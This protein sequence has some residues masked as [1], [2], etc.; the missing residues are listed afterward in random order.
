MF[1]M[2]E[3]K[4]I[5]LKVGEKQILTD[6]D[7]LIPEKKLILILKNLN[8]SLPNLFLNQIDQTDR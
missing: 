3:F 8:L 5:D 2:I 7:L 6:F 1:N 4:N